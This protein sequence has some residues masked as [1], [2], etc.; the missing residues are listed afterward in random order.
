M[1][2]RDSARD[3]GAAGTAR[4]LPVFVLWVP[5][6]AVV[7][8]TIG[9]AFPAGPGSEISLVYFKGGDM[10]VHLAG[11]GAFVL[12]ASTSAS[13]RRIPEP[14]F[15]LLWM[16]DVVVVGVITRGGM[17]AADGRLRRVPVR[18]IGPAVRAPAAD[19]RRSCFVA[20]A[21]VNPTID[22]GLER[23]LSLG[24]VIDN[25]TS[26]LGD[27]GQTGRGRAA[28]GHEELPAEVVATIVDYTVQR[29]L[30][31]DR[32]GVRH[33][34]RRRGRVPGDGRPRVARAAQRARRGA[35]PHGRPGP[36]SV[37]PPQRRLGR[38]RCSDGRSADRV[39]D[40][41]LARIAA[42]LFLYWVAMLVNASFDPY[43]QGPQGGIWYWTVIGAGFFLTSRCAPTGRSR[44][45]DR[46]RR[47]A[48]RVSAASAEST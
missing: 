34:P 32:Q 48:V 38:G 18:A 19:R 3:R 47:P 13:A 20:V 45:R 22:L 23:R 37:D 6:A 5:V 21:L 29:A 33:Q 8:L 39:R 43:L 36:R 12:L 15:W 2:T 40:P 16:L 46:R 28:P 31:L 30:L 35:R 42:W 44:S 27:R 25:V 11:V 4:L 9:D 17:F 7:A 10:G 41:F 14:L 26:V 1:L 24:Q